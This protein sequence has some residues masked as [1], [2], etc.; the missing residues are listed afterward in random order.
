M[1]FEEFDL[2]E[3]ILSGISC[4]GF[5]TPTPIQEKALPIVLSGKDLIGCAQTGTGK[6]GAFLIPLLSRISKEKT[7]KVH[8]LI[9]VPTRELAVQIDQQAEG[10]SYFSDISSYP[11]YGGGSGQSFE[12]E[13]TALIEGTDIIIATPGRLIMHLNQNYVDFS[14]L[15][16]LVLDEADRMLDM[17][18]MDSLTKIIG[19]LPQQRQ[20]LLFSATMPPKIRQLATTILKDP[21]EIN[22]AIS[23][24]AEK[25]DQKAY[26]VFEE[27]KPELF[28][29]VI[30][31]VSPESTIVF[32]SSRSNVK[33]I[34]R[35][36]KKLNHHARGISSDLD[37]KEREEVLTK[38]KSRQL[39]ILVATDVLSRGID[40]EGID[41]VINYDVPSEAEDYIHRIGRTARAEAKGK[42][43]TFITPKDQHKFR[44]IEK[45]MEMTIEKPVL[46]ESLGPVPEYSPSF[47]KNKRKFG[48]N[49]KGN[50]KGK[51]GKPFKNN[52]RP[53]QNGNTKSSDS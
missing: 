25:I 3:D 8:T 37:Q 33:D 19:H 32:S 2:S 53:P 40:I 28:K 4:L 34:L 30:Q 7:G 24:P 12:Q 47:K 26:M 48:N 29:H 45:L 41:L 21:E 52:R 50:W 9:V 5:K 46:P 43:I 35:E 17:G 6:T 49:K 44:R 20:N 51:S 10:L 14:N 31:E 13:R 38:F 22:I 27:Q 11:V 1:Q 39:P 16:T 36:L 23:R 18:F 42:A 15:K